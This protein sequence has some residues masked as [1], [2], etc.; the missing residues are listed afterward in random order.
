MA[1]SVRATRSV[2]TRNGGIHYFM[3]YGNDK[4]KI[5]VCLRYGKHDFEDA[6]MYRII[7]VTSQEVECKALIDIVHSEL[8]GNVLAPQIWYLVYHEYKKARDLVNQSAIGSPK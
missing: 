2:L 1:K 8:D 3:I 7:G 4:V 6:S 5:S